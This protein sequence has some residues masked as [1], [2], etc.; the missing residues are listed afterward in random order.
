MDTL[1]TNQEADKRIETPTDR[2]LVVIEEGQEQQPALTQALIWADALQKS[3][4]HVEITAA[5]AV[6][7]YASEINTMV[8]GTIL[9][10]L[11]RELVSEREEWLNALL[12]QQVEAFAEKTSSR[13]SPISI[14]ANVVWQKRP[15]KAVEQLLTESEKEERPISCIFKS[16]KQHPAYERLFMQ[17]DEWQLIRV[18]SKPVML[19][20]AAQ[21]L[22]EMHWLV[23]VDPHNPQHTE[24]NNLVMETTY[25]NRQLLGGEIE[26]IHAFPSIPEQMAPVLSAYGAGEYFVGTVPEEDD[27]RI[28]AFL[29]TFH[30]TRDQ[31]HSKHG[32]IDDI[33]NEHA[34]TLK[35]PLIV[36]GSRAHPGFSDRL[37]GHA[38]E[39]IIEQAEHNVLVIK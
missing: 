18:S 36:L 7:N 21:P 20:R 27:K 14:E 22:E 16:L 37:V 30:L 2:L 15:F 5:M 38:A 6:Y 23:G 11:R 8:T 19:V 34:K 10:N 9:H 12:D 32:A 3:G 29:N 26:L 39:R 28:E 33:V 4:H 17:I 31:L 13:P 25:H 35:N 24:L 1:S